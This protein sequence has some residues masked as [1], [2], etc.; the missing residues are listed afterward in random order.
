MNTLHHKNIG[1][2]CALTCCF[3]LASLGEEPSLQKP[4]IVYVIS[5]D[6]DYEHLGFM[7]NEI[8]RTPNLDRLA[9]EGTVFTTCH[10]TSSVCRPSLASLLSG[11]FPHQTGIYGNYHKANRKGN[12][13]IV[14]EKMLSS[15]QSLPNLLKQ[16]GYATYVSGKY[17]EG[18]VHRIQGGNRPERQFSWLR[19]RGAG[20]AFQVYRRA[21]G[22]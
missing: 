12:D 8:V 10:L 15:H 22:P 21:C 16:A 7:G 13:D 17:W 11:R 14:G 1:K 3:V 18:G 2:L 5:D 4:N 20:L 19:A 6:H 9:D